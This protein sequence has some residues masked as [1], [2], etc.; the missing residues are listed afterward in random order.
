MRNPADQ[1]QD[2]PDATNIHRS[3]CK[4]SGVGLVQKNVASVRIKNFASTQSLCSVPKELPCAI[5][6]EVDEANRLYGVL[7][8]CL[9]DRPVRTASGLSG[10]ARFGELIVSPAGSSQWASSGAAF[11]YA[12][13]VTMALGASFS[14]AAARAGVLAGLA[15][16]DMVFARFVVAGLTTL[17]LLLYWGLPTLAGIGWRRGLALLLTGG[18]LFAILQTGGYAFAPLAHGGVIA[19][20]TVTVLSTL[21]AGVIL[22]EVLTRSHLVGSVLVLAGILLIGWQ[23][24][25]GSA[26]GERAWIGDALF[27][28]SSV[29]WAGYTLLMRRWRIDAMRATCVVA[30]LSLCAVVPVYL[31]SRGPSHLSELPGATLVFQGVVQGLLQSI[32]TTTAYNR[33]IAILGVSRAVLFPAIVPAISVLIGIPALGEIPNAPQLAGLIV[34]SI[35]MFVAVGALDCLFAPA[36]TSVS[37]ETNASSGATPLEDIKSSATTGEA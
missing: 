27:F 15:P 18:P 21:A 23:G 4:G 33:S 19:P 37:I 36:A 1:D 22:G 12:C 14:F 34:V 2:L 6:L 8:K 35:G 10:F 31:G 7:S 26:P 25:F 16:D 13:G 28:L 5:N 29:L 3:S 32:I 11:G 9:A 30:V 20:S 17:P 24:I